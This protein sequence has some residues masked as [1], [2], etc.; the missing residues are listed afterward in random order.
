MNI[1]LVLYTAV[2]III[3]VV[4]VII[5]YFWSLFNKYLLTTYYVPGTKRDTRDTMLNKI[6]SHIYPA[7]MDFYLHH[8]ILR[9]TIH[10]LTQTLIFTL[11]QTLE[12]LTT[13]FFPEDDTG[14]PIIL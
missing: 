5:I 7:N 14:T 13:A 6:N 1:L 12:F 2:N 3:L 11:P 10:L 8:V 4:I 9:F